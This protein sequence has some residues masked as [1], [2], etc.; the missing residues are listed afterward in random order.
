MNGPGVAFECVHQQGMHLWEDHYLLEIISPETSDP[1]ADCEPGE[2][3]R[4]LMAAPELDRNDLIE[5]DG[6]DEMMIKVELSPAR[7]DGHVDLLVQLEK[8]LVDKL[9]AEILTK[10]KVELVAPETLPVSEGKAKRV[11]DRRTL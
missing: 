11:I 7:F 10:P 3:E 8:R 6:L 1:V 5:L 4:I 9:R 2:I